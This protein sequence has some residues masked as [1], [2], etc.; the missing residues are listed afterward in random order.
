[1]N[2]HRCRPTYLPCP[3]SPRASQTTKTV[4]NTADESWHTSLTSD[5][6]YN[7]TD[8]HNEN[9]TMPGGVWHSRSTICVSG[10]CPR[11]PLAAWQKA[12]FQLTEQVFLSCFG[13]KILGLKETVGGKLDP[14]LDCSCTSTT[15]IV[16]NERLKHLSNSRDGQLW[17][18]WP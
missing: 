8:Q 17:L 13:S 10:Q 9:D 16:W 5:E 18:L 11:Q 14:S 3:T 2:L 7:T 6:N 1:M 15:I 12:W 4:S